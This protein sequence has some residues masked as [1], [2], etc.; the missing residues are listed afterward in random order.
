MTEKVFGIIVRMVPQKWK[1]VEDFLD[2]IGSTIIFVKQA[3]VNRKLVLKNLP[4]W[5]D[6][7]ENDRTDSN[8]LE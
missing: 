1:Q 8:R 4:S 7:K 2:D 5:E 6:E 3:D